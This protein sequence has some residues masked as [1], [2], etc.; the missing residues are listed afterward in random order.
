[1][2]I[3]SNLQDLFRII[4]NLEERNKSMNATNTTTWLAQL[5]K[6][7]ILLIGLIIVLMFAVFGGLLVGIRVTTGHWPVQSKSTQPEEKW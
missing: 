4:L 7:P 3:G 1:M 6:K 2:R 5:W